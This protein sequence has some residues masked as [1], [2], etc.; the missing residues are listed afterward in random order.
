[1][2]TAFLKISM[3]PLHL[4]SIVGKFDA[5]EVAIGNAI[6]RF[7]SFI[8]SQVAHFATSSSAEVRVQQ[9]LA[10]KDG[11]ELEELKMEINRSLRDCKLEICS[12]NSGL[13]KFLMLNV[14][15]KILRL[16][17]FLGTD[18]VKLCNR[19][20]VVNVSSKRNL[21]KSLYLLSFRFGFVGE[22]FNWKDF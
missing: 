17:Q 12:V 9:L 22:Y 3:A 11:K 2:D 5:A 18:N 7:E 6:R 14:D 10:I 21:V 4:R 1:M 19:G 8:G 20:K 15:T 16:P 13:I